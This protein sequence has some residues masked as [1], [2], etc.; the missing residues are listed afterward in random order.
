MTVC[1]FCGVTLKY[2][3]TVQIWSKN[4]VIKN[5]WFTWRRNFVRFFAHF[6]RCVKYEYSSERNMFQVDVANKG[7]IHSLRCVYSVLVWAQHI[8]HHSSYAL[9]CLLSSE[10]SISRATITADWCVVS[11]WAATALWSLLG[12]VSKLWRKPMQMEVL[13]S[14]LVDILFKTGSAQNCFA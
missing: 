14:E 13:S 5:M 11:L 6:E 10:R 4:L 3:E 12:G 8:L 7:A 2:L 9:R 1:L